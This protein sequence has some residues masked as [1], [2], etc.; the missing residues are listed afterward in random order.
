MVYDMNHS[1]QMQKK[2]QMIRHICSHDSAVIL[3]IHAHIEK[4]V[5]DEFIWYTEAEIQFNF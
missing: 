1:M 4:F 5:F 2:V 3:I